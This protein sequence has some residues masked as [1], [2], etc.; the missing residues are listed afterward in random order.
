M[1][2]DPRAV[3]IAG[4]SGRALAAAARQAGETVIV[5][6][7]Y[8]DQD[9]R[10]LARACTVVPAGGHGLARGALLAAIR[11]LRGQ[12][13][14]LVYGGGFE[15]DPAL[16]GEIA[17]IMPILGNPPE[18]VAAVKDPFRFAGLLARLGLPH[19][20]IRRAAPAGGGWL[21]KASGGSGGAHIA[22]AAG[23][24]VRRGF[25]VQQALPGRAVSAAFVADGR[26]AR[27]LAFTEQWPSPQTGA[28][29]QYGGCAGPVRLATGLAEAVAA[30]CRGLAAAAG[31]VGLNSL[32]MLVDGDAFHVLEVNPRPG[33]TL[34]VLDGIG[35][36]SLWRLHREALAGR[37]PRRGFATGRVRAAQVVYAPRRLVIPR[38][39]AWPAWS[40]DRGWPGT[41]IGR[42]EPVCTVQ[43]TGA[44]AAQAR[45]RVQWRTAELLQRL[46]AGRPSRSA[47][48]DRYGEETALA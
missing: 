43:A 5:L 45:Q 40:A 25:Y 13:Q 19:P 27:V 44:S 18:V 35:G 20:P 9:T 10:R 11:R 34:D 33:A 8:G 22:H 1:H 47:T 15:A 41:A 48:G 12:V 2:S 24:R 29:F 4:L 30:A 6:D 23:G 7:R 46:G 32:D 28:P 16:L 36:R 39:F 3:L 38:G 14:G 37:L 21:R 26:T 17:E 31:L 42:G